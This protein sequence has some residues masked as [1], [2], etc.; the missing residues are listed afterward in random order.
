[1]EVRD[2]LRRARVARGLRQQDLADALGV[3][4][5]AVLM[6]ENPRYQRSVPV[7]FRKKV[8]EILDI[9][10]ADLV[11]QDTPAPAEMPKPKYPRPSPKEHGLITTNKLETQLLKLFRLMPEPMK[12]VQ[13]AQFVECL[14]GSDPDY[15]GRN[16]FNQERF[17]S[18]GA[19]HESR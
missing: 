14:S 18:G 11:D 13:L 5:T 16:A 12:L 9:D 15:N 3:S 8:S 7:R 17:P 2:R 4:A 6:W 10:E 1:M 19:A